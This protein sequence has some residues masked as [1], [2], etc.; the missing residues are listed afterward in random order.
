MKEAIEVFFDGACPLCRREIA[1]L[2]KLDRRRA[3][4]RFTDID[5]PGF[6]PAA[7]GR[8]RTELMAHI[9]GRLRDGTWVTG[10]EVFRRL[11][12]AV[13]FGALVAMT[14]LPGIRHVL[15][16]AYARFAKNR[17][18]ITGRCTDAS[19]EVAP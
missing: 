17:L 2:Q 13:G 16:A 6:D 9:H 19:C 7:I 5:A 11:Y 12:A 15:D 10:V 1:V 4:I 8:T 14:R 3:A 18:R